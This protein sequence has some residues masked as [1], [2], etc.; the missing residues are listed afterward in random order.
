M[1]SYSS[2]YIFYYIRSYINSIF[3]VVYYTITQDIVK[4]ICKNKV[5]CRIKHRRVVVDDDQ[6]NIILIKLYSL[7]LSTCPPIHLK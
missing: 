4:N 3:L 6:K 7:L 1:F 5:S 2:I